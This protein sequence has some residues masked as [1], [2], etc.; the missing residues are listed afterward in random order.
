MLSSR[1]VPTAGRRAAKRVNLRIPFHVY[2]RDENGAT[3]QSRAET[4]N[5]SS[6]GGCL[7]LDKDPIRGQNLKIVGPKGAAFIAR[8]C[9]SNYVMRKN[10]RFVG[11][12]LTRFG[13][14]WVLIDKNHSFPR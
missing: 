12:A 3:F 4:V 2:G 7:V 9:W 8:V 6:K 13:R 10:I 11:F 5:V 14:E 1:N